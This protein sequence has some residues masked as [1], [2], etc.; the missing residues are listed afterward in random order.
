[1]LKTFSTIPLALALSACV[2][3]P[4]VEEDSASSNCNTYTKSMSLEKIEVH[5]NLS[6][7]CN[8]EECLAALLATATVVSAG[9]AIISGSIVL[10]GN[11]V[12][13][14]EYQG[15]CSDGY[16]NAA[17]Q[18]FRES[19]KRSEQTPET[20]K[21]ERSKDVLISSD[22]LIASDTAATILNQHFG[23]RQSTGGYT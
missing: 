17:K 4:R 23:I 20:V 11:T 8:N 10:T 12:H 2:Y 22:F 9:S 5:Q 14:L 3:V 6:V 15:T 21:P 13:W 1:M 7:R 19:L 16:L 18:L